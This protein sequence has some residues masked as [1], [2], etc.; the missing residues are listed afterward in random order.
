VRPVALG[1]TVFFALA[2]SA[3]AADI[4]HSIALTTESVG[5]RS[6]IVVV[7]P[8]ARTVL[9]LTPGSTG[10]EGSDGSPTWS[11]DGM[12]LAFHTTAR[13]SAGSRLRAGRSGRR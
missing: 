11:P 7:D 9:E 4:T 6:H 8:E 13:A 5:A 2:L 3:A 12:K 10:E 1:L